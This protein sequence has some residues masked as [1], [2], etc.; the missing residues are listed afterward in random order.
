[1]ITGKKLTPADI[2]RIL[3]RRKW[4]ILLPAILGLAAASLVVRR[5]PNHYRSETLIMVMPQ[6]IPD[7]YV[8]STVTGKIEDR[9]AT[10]TEQIQSRSRLERIILDL[11]LYKEERQ[12]GAMEDV[13][14]QLR[15]DIVVTQEGKESFRVSY[16]SLDAQTAK[17]VTERLASLFIEENLRDR[18][19]LAQ[20]TNQFL[21]AQL[22]DAK[23]RLIEHEK[24]LE[25]FRRR[26]SGQLP[27]QVPANIQAIQNTQTQLQSL[28]EATNRVR[29]RRLLVERQIADVQTPEAPTPPVITNPN[30]ADDQAGQTTGQQLET[31]KAR[32]NVLLTRAKPDHPDVRALERVIRELQTKLD[33]ESRN[34]GGVTAQPV[35]VVEAQRIKRLRDYTAQL[36]DIDREL[37]DKQQ[38]ERHLRGIIADYQSKLDVVPT[39]E[40][41]LVD[42]TRDYTTLQTSYQTLLAK[43]EESKIA[44]DLERKN[45]GEQF[46]VLDPARVPERPF[47]PDRRLIRLGGA[48]GGL[49]LG[50]ALAGFLEYRDT[51]FNA[52]DDVVRVLSLPVLAIVPQLTSALDEQ[53][54]RR[55]HRR[56]FGVGTVLVVA[57]LG[58]ALLMWKFFLQL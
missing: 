25:E 9:L 45:I 4:L 27:S 3:L 38:Q 6:R 52:Q 5:L 35:T 41:E 15:S 13:V 48:F 44:V 10:L 28:V 54:A 29:E 21:D 7:A 14:R 53:A 42:L 55:R 19:N 22:E 47:S 11:D 24:K 17:T 36:Q 51:S 40:S 26:Y 46:R 20:D 23:R 16:V 57:A 1:M 37:V 12:K 50:L 39:R 18:A 34:T 31:A 49:F 8:K 32:L 2:V 43:R 56:L 58:T 33:A 30:R